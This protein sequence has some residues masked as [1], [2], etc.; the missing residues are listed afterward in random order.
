[1]IINYYYVIVV[2]YFKVLV[3]CSPQ[4]GQPINHPRFLPGFTQI[5]DY[6]TATIITCSVPLPSIMVPTLLNYAAS[7]INAF[8]S[9]IR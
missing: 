4:P 1:M 8:V 2:A 5:Q 7:S 9:R 3:R 6:S